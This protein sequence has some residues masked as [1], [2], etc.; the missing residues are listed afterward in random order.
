MPPIP[1]LSRFA[2]PCP[3]LSPTF[4][5]ALSHTVAVVLVAAV[6]IARSPTCLGVYATGYQGL[7][8]FIVLVQRILYW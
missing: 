8:L 7:N 6:A 4:A 5:I 1:Y 2:S 3:A